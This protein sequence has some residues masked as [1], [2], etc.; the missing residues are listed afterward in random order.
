[1][2]WNIAD[3]VTPEE[4]DQGES[5]AEETWKLNVWIVAVVEDDEDQLMENYQSHNTEVNN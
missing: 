5:S 4:M 3:S 2:V 1:M